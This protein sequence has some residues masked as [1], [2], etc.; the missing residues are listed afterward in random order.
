MERRSPGI[1]SAG[2]TR[3]DNIV[4]QHQQQPGH[5][6]TPTWL[7]RAVPGSLNRNSSR[8][9]PSSTR[10]MQRLDGEDAKLPL[11]QPPKRLVRASARRDETR[12]LRNSRI[13][14]PTTVWL[15]AR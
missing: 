3:S 12:E 8:P 11:L 7:E 13:P 9:N 10:W 14:G 5:V 6:R 2:L 4:E 1:D 15:G